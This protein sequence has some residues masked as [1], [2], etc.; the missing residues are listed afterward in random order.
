MATIDDLLSSKIEDEQL[1]SNNNYTPDVFTFDCGQL[2]FERMGDDHFELM[3]ADIY[4]ARAEEGKDSWFDQ[5]CRLNDGADQGRDVILLQDSEPVGVIQCKRYKGNVGLPQIIQEICKFFLYAKIMPQLVPAIGAE[6]RY[7]VAVSDGATGDLFEFMTSKEQSRFDTLREVFEKKAL[8]AR[9]SSKKL[10]AHPELKDLDKKQ[11][12]DVVWERVAN[13]RTHLHKK[14]SLSRMIA[15]FPSI[16]STYFRLES[17]TAKLVLEIKKALASRG[18][19]LSDDD[20]KLV[21]NVRTEY[22]KLKLSSSNRFNIGLIQGDN[23]LP[24]IRSM[25]Q[26]N[27]GILHD[28]FGSRPVVVTAGSVAVKANQWEEVD[29]L[30]KEHPYPLVLTVG[31]GEVSGTTLIEWMKSDNMSWIDSKWSPA[32]NRLYRAGWCWIKDSEQEIHDCYILVENE[33]GEQKYDHANISLRLAFEDAILWPTLGNDFT[34]PFESPKSPL[35]RLVASQAEDKAS[36]RNLILASQHVDEITK[37]LASSADYFGQR[38][39]SPLASCIANSGRLKSCNQDI[40]SATG[41][42]PARDTE[43]NTRSTPPIVQPPSRVM[44]RSCNGALTLTMDWDTEVIL[45]FVK[46]HRLKNNHVEDELSPQDLE[47]HEFFYRYPPMEGY[48]NHVDKELKCFN[49]LIQNAELADSMGFTYRTKYGVSS[50]QPFSLDDM[51][52]SGEYVMKAVQALSYIK[53]HQ[54]SKWV[55]EEKIEGHI[56]YSEPTS[57]DFHVLAWA[58]HRYPI[59]QMEADL[60]DWAREASGN[61]SL[62]VFAN[63]KGK[64]NDRKPSH[65]RYDFTSTPPVRKSITDI[66]QPNNV[67]IF[68]LGELESNYDNERAPSIEKYMGDLLERRKELDD[69]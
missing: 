26:P 68:D 50:N 22:I 19:I 16:K 62:V 12:C 6:F 1:R 9:N 8:K 7:Y 63:A 25:L 10:K 44:R 15:D 48:L 14:D 45:E 53:S 33:T 66:Q 24:F 67:Y 57:G 17:D 27:S 5:A 38:S 34:A 54:N 21:S 13:L 65:D 36:R 41:I 31:C 43:H 55:V 60:Y 29:N 3:M 61:P 35:R 37:V 39:H 4:T 64:V 20:E 2:P 11:L 28:N 51:S 47:F 69:K 32:P 23:S 46:S 49:T 30:I 56:E 58:N 18:V 52:N 42:F 40:Y 59:R